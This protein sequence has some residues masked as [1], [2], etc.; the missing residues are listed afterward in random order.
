MATSLPAFGVLSLARVFSLSYAEGLQP[1][2]VT[3]QLKAIRSFVCVTPPPDRP[4][5]RNTFSK[6]STIPKHGKERTL[7]LQFTRRQ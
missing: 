7:L 2:V 5:T 3:P 4:A 6:D 1:M